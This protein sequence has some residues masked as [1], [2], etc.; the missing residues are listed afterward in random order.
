MADEITSESFEEFKNS[1]SY[2]SRSDLNFKFL[3]SYTAEEASKFFQDLLW[4]LGD[5]LDDGDIRQL[6]EY[7]FQ[8][9]SKGYADPGRYIYETAPFTSIPKPVSELRM[10]LL[11]SSGHFVDGHDPK[12]FG[13]EN[14][15]QQEAEARI[16]EFVRSEPVLSEIPVNTP[17]EKLRVRHGGYDIRGAQID[18]NVNFP[19]TRL[20]EL[21]KEGKIGELFSPVFSFV[22]ACS[23]ANLLK[24]TGAAW[25]KVFQE[26][27]IEALLLVPV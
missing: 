10:A 14:M 23:Q 7:I 21:Q 8:S 24:Q 4:K 13:I 27:E 15:T 19:L 20:S 17:E 26:Y 9:Q 11:T 16:S 12:P 3:K 6:E 1:F 25:L 22:G 2:G 5:S 18:P